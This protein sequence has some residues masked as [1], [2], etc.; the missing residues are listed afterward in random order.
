MK[1]GAR[2]WVLIAVL[3][4]ATL[5][6]AHL[7][8]GESTPPARPL[9]EFPAKIGPYASVIDWPLDQDTL[10][11]LK[12]NDYLYRGYWEPGLGKDMMGLYIGYFRSQRSGAGIHSPKNCMPGA[13]WNPVMSSVDRLTLPDGRRAPVNL[14]ILRKGLDEELVLYWYQAHGRIVASEYWGKFY[15]VYDALRLNRT[16]GALVRITVPIRNGDEA[17]A[18]QRA[19]AFAQQITGKVDQIIPR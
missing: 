19:L 14:Y 18:Q 10:D 5:G 1:A 15:L 17:T 12:V 6:M 9:S 7:S 3:L 8:H 11:V 2:Y 13:G 16:D 4:A